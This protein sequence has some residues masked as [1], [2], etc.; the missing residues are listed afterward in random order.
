M[1]GH[2]TDNAKNDKDNKNDRDRKDRCDFSRS[3]QIHR[4]SAGDY[5]P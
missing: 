2:G 1:F 4:Y 3:L 5:F